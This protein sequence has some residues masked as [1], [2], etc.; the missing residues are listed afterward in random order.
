MSDR[1]YSQKGYQEHDRSQERGQGRS[2]PSSRG[3]RDPTER[4]RGR[5]VGKRTLVVFRCAVCGTEN[6]GE[7][8]LNLESTCLKCNTDLHTCTHCTWFDSGAQNQC[9]KPVEHY[10]SSKAKRNS[11]ELF[12]PKAASEFAGEP[13][14]PKDAKSPKSAKSA[15]DDLFNF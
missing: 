7:G 12:E 15:F 14:A 5:T 10:V 11:C 2:R 8:K 13:A 6:S 9:R 4:P 3:P 1:K